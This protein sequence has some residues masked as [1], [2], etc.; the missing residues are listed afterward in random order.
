MR[1]MIEAG[2]ADYSVA[3]AYY[4]T[5]DQL[6]AVFD[7]HRVDLIYDALVAVPYQAAG[8]LSYQEYRAHFGN[9]EETTGGTAIFYVQDAAGETQGTALYSVDYQRGVVTFADNQ[10]GAAYY[11]T[12]RSYDLNAIA[13]EIWRTKAS[14][15]VSAVNFSTDNHSVSRSQLFEHCLDMAA[16]YEARS[17]DAVKSVDLFRSDTDG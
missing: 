11:L 3:G 1:G 8:S 14:H 2:T 13:A 7:R 9:L 17:G 4:W 6:D 16:Q 12:A 15:Y 10:Q 5:D